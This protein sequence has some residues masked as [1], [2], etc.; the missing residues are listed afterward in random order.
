MVGCVAGRQAVTG[1]GHG[2]T[3]VNPEAAGAERRKPVTEPGIDTHSHV[4]ANDLGLE[5]GECGASY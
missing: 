4:F 2:Q 3:R 5:E 1:W